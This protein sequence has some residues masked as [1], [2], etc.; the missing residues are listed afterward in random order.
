M[1]GLKIAVY[2]SF[3]IMGLS[4]LGGYA[5]NLLPIGL[6]SLDGW[7]Y[8]TRRF[9]HD[10][11]FYEQ[12]FRVRKW[13]DFLPDGAALF[14]KGFRKKKLMT[15][16]ADYLLTYALETC[17]AELLHYLI[18][19]AVPISLSFQP[20][21]ALIIT[22]LVVFAINFPCIISLRY[23]RIRLLRLL[24]HRAGTGGDGN[25]EAPIIHSA[26]EGTIPL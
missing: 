19:L 3:L 23:N 24:A 25:G 6:F 10:G 21:G 17:R 7:L 14:R 15:R 1:Q 5:I 16:N 26:K 13:K 18:F 4:L 12:V 20:P 22:F 9:E 8:K 11:R 2:N